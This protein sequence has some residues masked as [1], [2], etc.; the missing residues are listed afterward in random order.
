MICCTFKEIYL[1]NVKAGDNK[2]NVTKLMSLGYTK[3]K[4]L[5]SITVNQSI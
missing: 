3:N 1:E 2:C 4:Q 5:A